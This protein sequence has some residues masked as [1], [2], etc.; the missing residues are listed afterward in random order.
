MQRQ[1]VLDWSAPIVP[2][3]SIA[4]IPFGTPI[5]AL[6]SALQAHSVSPEDPYVVRF[7]N[8]PV[9]RFEADNSGF[10]VR[11]AEIKKNYDWQDVVMGLDFTNGLFTFARV[12]SVGWDGFSYKGKLF[13][14]VGLGDPANLLLS[15][16][17]RVI[18]DDAE[19]WLYCSG[20]P[21]SIRVAGTSC[22]LESDPKQPVSIIC[23]ASHSLADEP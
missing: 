17:Q 21:L 2:G 4:G 6:V 20:G 13:G 8:S 10:C 19:E 3:V 1:L 18:Y 22:P 5:D 12:D 9:L 23:V 15:H 14:S 7:A 11:A 16:Y